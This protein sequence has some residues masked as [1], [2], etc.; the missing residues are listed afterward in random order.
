M[1]WF[2]FKYILERREGMYYNRFTFKSL[3]NSD[4]KIGVVV[5][6]IV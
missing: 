2:S 1:S 6:I 5:D 3:G 4:Y